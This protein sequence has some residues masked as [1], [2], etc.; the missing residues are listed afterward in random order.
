[1]QEQILRRAEAE[2]HIGTL[3]V[4]NQSVSELRRYIPRRLEH[5][6]TFDEEEEIGVGRMLTVLEFALRTISV[7]KKK[8][9]KS[10][11]PRSPLTQSREERKSATLFFPLLRPKS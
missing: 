4:T 2:T 6:Y 5:R 8:H 10:E 1:M 3:I 11:A 7:H 9:S